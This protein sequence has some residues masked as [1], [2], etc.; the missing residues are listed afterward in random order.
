MQISNW[1]K[2]I[3]NMDSSK[4]QEYQNHIHCNNKNIFSFNQNNIEKWK[5]KLEEYDKTKKP[6]KKQK[7]TTS[8]SKPNISKDRIMKF[9]IKTRKAELKEALNDIPKGKK[10]YAIDDM[11][12]S[13]LKFQFLGQIEIQGPVYPQDSKEEDIGNFRVFAYYFGPD[14]KQDNLLNKNY[15]KALNVVG[16]D[17]FHFT[18]KTKWKD[19]AHITLKD[20]IGIQ[21]SIIPQLDNLLSLVE[22]S[23]L[24]AHDFPKPE[25]IFKDIPDFFS[26][27]DPRFIAKKFKATQN[28]PIYPPKKKQ[29]ESLK[30]KRNEKQKDDGEEPSKK[31]SS[32]RK[33]VKSKRHVKMHEDVPKAIPLTS[34]NSIL[35]PEDLQNRKCIIPQNLSFLWEDF[36]NLF[37][38]YKKQ[39]QLNRSNLVNTDPANIMEYS[40]SS[41]AQAII[42]ACNPRGVVKKTILNIGNANGLTKKNDN[43]VELEQLILENTDVKVHE[44]MRKEIFPYLNSL[45]IL[46]LLTKDK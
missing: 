36:A 17:E 25:P 32:K 18:L 24:F 29:Q 22:V 10:T 5:K 34:S 7:T 45:I 31:E 8:K 4:L 21:E 37:Q 20:G 13:I 30:R 19:F 41:I 26:Q 46:S 40:P 16:L 23:Q 38:I 28:K 2:L 14:N 43:M 1:L 3:D 33:H 39:N 27:F 15:W 9:I 6:L 44:M 42:L 11:V 12:Q 35:V